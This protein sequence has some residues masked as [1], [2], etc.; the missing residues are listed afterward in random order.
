[1]SFSRQFLALGCLLSASVSI[2]LPASAH[3]AAPRGQ[4]DQAAAHADRGFEYARAGKVDSAEAELRQAAELDPSD[5]AVLA[6]LGTVLAQEQKLEESTAFF[7]RALRISPGDLTV[8]RYLAANLWQ[9]HL[10]RDAKDN[11][12]IILK[13][14]PDDPASQLLLGMVSENM[15]D[16]P[17]AGLRLN[18]LSIRRV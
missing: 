11:L 13:R 1:M 9:L 8:R 16:Y 14:K 10:Y 4:R 5:P 6:A 7:R 18:R 3:A 15:G 2:F 12:Q 17:G